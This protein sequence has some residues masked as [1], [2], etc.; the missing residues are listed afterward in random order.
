MY[1]FIDD[2]FNI[3]KGKCMYGCTYCYL[4]AMAKRF[5]RPQK[6]PMLDEKEF[7]TN[8][9]RDLFIFLGSSIEMFAPNIPDYWI[10][11]TLEHCHKYDNKYMFH[12]K[13]PARM[14]QFQH[15]MPL[16]SVLCVTI[17]TNRHYKDIMRFAPSPE[18]RITPIRFDIEVNRRHNLHLTIEPIMDFDKD[19]FVRWINEIYPG[20]AQIN[21]G[22]DSGNNNLPEPN[23]EK[24]QDFIADL[25]SLG[26]NVF[27]KQ[28]LKRLL[29]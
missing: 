11:K 19:V 6:P 21:I 3:I 18:E 27:E 8:L 2:T 22:A 26:F 12:T 1:P 15:L 23:K 7:K 16:N 25:K 14:L 10:L 29:K 17:E 24:L 20:P 28:N 5:E 4:I 9:G 13:N